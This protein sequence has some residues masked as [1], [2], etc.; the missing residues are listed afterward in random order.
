MAFRR[1]VST[2]SIVARCP[3][4]GQL[5]VAVQ[6]HWFSV[7]TVVPWAEAG[8]GAVATQA[9]ADPSY[10]PQGLELMRRG[11]DAE[12]ALRSLLTDDVEP[13]VRQ[14]AFVDAIGVVAVHTGE[15]CVAEAGHVHGDGF[16][17]QANMMAR[18]TVWEA[19]AETF[20]S[21]SGD[22]AARMLDALDAA[23][24]EGGDLRG[25]QSAALLVVTGEPTGRFWEDRLFDVRVE[26]H[27][28]PLDELRRLVRLRRAYFEMEAGDNAIVAGD[29]ETALDRYSLAVSLMPENPEMLFWKAA[30]L[31]NAGRVEDAHSLFI[32]VFD[33]VPAWRDMV[34]RLADTGFIEADTASV[35]RILGD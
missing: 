6:S 4:T 13:E 29:E 32:E 17:T 15:R 30:C 24:R 9:F 8:V 11:V 22:L 23:E 12:E 31:L 27:D 18:P 19:M 21:S 14:V 7:G 20:R 2:Y 5:G 26:D 25:R 35:E 34:R 28:Q 3:D 33:M 1:P 10:G 16:S